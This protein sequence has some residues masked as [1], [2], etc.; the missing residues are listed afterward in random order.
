[1]PALAEVY[2]KEIP[3]YNTR[4][5]LKPGLSGWA[6]INNYDVPRGGVDIEKTTAKL[7]YDLFYLE[8]RS[9]LLDLQIGFKTIATIILRTGT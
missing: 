5:F 4:H 1:M 2:A 3:Y 8:R 7:S 9:L 6:Q